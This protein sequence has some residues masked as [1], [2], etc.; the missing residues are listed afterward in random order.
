MI[1]SVGPREGRRDPDPA[2]E[3]EGT[4]RRPDRLGVPKSSES[5]TEPVGERSA[6]ASLGRGLAVNL[7]EQR[8]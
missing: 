6:R 8:A 4:F 2:D 3:S 1:E 7:L 5:V